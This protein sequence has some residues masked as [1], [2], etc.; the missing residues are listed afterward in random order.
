MT[1]N[2]FF[3]SLWVEDLRRGEFQ[4]RSRNKRYVHILR[5]RRGFSLSNGADKITDLRRS[6]SKVQLH[7]S[8]IVEAQA[9]S[10][11][12]YHSPLDI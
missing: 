4:E 9:E 5:H 2:P 11:S 3:Q 12:E 6:R 1:S 7:S 8:G 10:K